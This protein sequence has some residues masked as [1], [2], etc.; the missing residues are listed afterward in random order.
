MGL[1]H[2]QIIIKEPQPL[3]GPVLVWGEK[4]GPDGKLSHLHVVHS[5]ANV[6]IF[7]LKTQSKAFCL[8]VLLFN[9]AGVNEGNRSAND[10]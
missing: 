8:Y 7:K 4:R 5:E 6:G 9:F 10:N 3:A 1:E 2:L